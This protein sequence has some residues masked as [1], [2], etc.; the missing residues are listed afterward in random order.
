[1]PVFLRLSLVSPLIHVRRGE[2]PHSFLHRRSTMSLLCLLPSFFE[3]RAVKMITDLEAQSPGKAAP[4]RSFFF[5]F[6]VPSL[7]ERR[8]RRFYPPPPVRKNR[9]E[10]RSLARPTLFCVF[11]QGFR[12]EY[13]SKR[14]VVFLSH[15]FFLISVL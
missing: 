14:R 8:K 13:F 1:M 7:D 3:S 12:R 5:L 4:Q 9:F 2:F 10:P 6:K 11:H 15:M